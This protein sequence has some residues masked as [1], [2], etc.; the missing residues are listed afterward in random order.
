MATEVTQSEARRE[1]RLFVSSPADVAA[2]RE[3]VGRVIERLDSA[4]RFAVHLRTIRWEQDYYTADKT[5]Q[6]KIENPQ[7]CDLVVSILW[8]RLGSELPPD[9]ERMPD[10]RPYPSGTVYELLKALE[11]KGQRGVPDVLVYRKTLGVVTPVEDPSAAQ[12]VQDQLAAVHR[13]WT[14]RFVSEQG[15]FL[16]GYHSF[17]TTE[18]F[19]AQFESH[20]RKWLA[21]QGLLGRPVTWPIAEKGSPFRGLEP[22]DV[23]HERILFGRSA[24]IENAVALVQ[25]GLASGTTFLLITGESGAGKSS[26]ARA[27]VIP[28]LMRLSGPESADGWRL[29]RM[30]PGSGAD[31]LQLLAEALF[32]KEA[33]PELAS[34][35]Y[36]EPR[37]LRV[38]LSLGGVATAL[39]VTRTLE[40]V[41]TGWAKAQGLDRPTRMRLV[42]LVD[43]LEELFASNIEAGLREEFAAACAALVE[44][45]SV[46][47]IATLR[48]DAYP[49]LLGSDALLRLKSAGAT[50]DVRTPDKSQIRE[51]VT[52][53]A[54]AAGL[55][56]DQ[57]PETGKRLNDV[58]IEDAA[59]QDAL[60]LLQFA[61]ERLYTQMAARLSTSGRGLAHAEAANLVLRAADYR[62]FGGLEGALRETAEGAINRV[63]TEAQSRLPRLVRA[64]LRRSDAG[65]TLE[66]A[67][68]AHFAEDGAALRLI[69]ALV[70]ARI[71]VRGGSG[72]SGAGIRFAHEAVRRSWPRV[73]EI[74][75]SSETFYR[76][77]GDVLAAQARWSEA[78]RRH[79][80]AED[81]LVTPGVPLAEAERMASEYRD[82]LTSETLAFIARSGQRARRRQRWLQAAAAAFAV[83]FVASAAAGA[84]AWLKRGEASAAR[85]IAESERR[86]AEQQRKLAVEQEK[87]AKEQRN[88]ALLTQSRFLADLAN[89]R[90]HTGDAGTGILLALEAL[91]DV[92][93]GRERPFAPEAEV[94]LLSAVHQLKEVAILAHADKVATASF[95]PD[96]RRVVTTSE[97]KTAR[98][99]DVETGKPITAL[100][101]H[102]ALASAVF[103]PDGARVITASWDKTA[104]IWDAETGKQISILQGH[105]DGV[106]SAV[107]SPDGRRGLTASKD[108]TARVWETETGRQITILQ[109]HKGEVWTALFSPD[110]RR[111]LTASYDRTAR[112]WD[113]ETGKQVTALEGHTDR[114]NSSRFSPD[115]RRVLTAS[116][117]KTARLWD[118]QTGEPIFVLD[119]H[120]GAVTAAFSPDGRRVVTAPADTTA[121]VWD[122][123]TGKP[124][125]SLQ[126]HTDTI[127]RAAFSPDGRHIFTASNDRTARVWD[128]ATG[129]QISILKGHTGHLSSATFSPDGRHI[130]T[131][132]WD[133][134]ARLWNAESAEPI[135]I[136]GHESSPS[137][138]PDGQRILTIS[139]SPTARMWDVRV[140][141]SDTGKQVGI[142]QGHT[143]QLKSA[144]FS[145]DGLRI[146]TAS[147]DET[148]RIWDA[149]SGRQVAI[150]QGHAGQL[151]SAEFSPDARLVLTRPETGRVAQLWDA[152]TGKQIS[153]L[154]GHTSFVNSAAFSPDSRHVVTAS[155]DKTARVWNAATGREIAIL[156]G[157]TAAV[158]HAAFSPDGRRVVT[159]SQSQD[160]TARIWDVETGKQIAIL[161]GHESAVWSAAF[162]PDG[163]HVLTASND[164][165]ARIWDAETGKTTAVLGAHANSETSAVFSP[166]GRRVLTTAYLDHVVRLWD[167]DSGEQIA[168][169]EGDSP[170]PSAAFSPDGRRIAIASGGTVRIWPIF[171]STQDLI[172]RAKEIVPRCLTGEQR[173]A[174]FLAPEPPAWCIERQR[175]PYDTQDWKLWLKYM[176]AQAKPPFPGTPEWRSWLSAAARQSG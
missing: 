24:E 130:V 156:Q 107:F 91:P 174:A 76:V 79:V 152:A 56:F 101:G 176:R 98:V 170:L 61:L 20:L 116:W 89:Q 175:W 153:V 87:E 112:L 169:L 164:K 118:A 33:L 78:Q 88:Q 159:A 75:S 109:G 71:L 111:V 133:N 28:R 90:T 80:R 108:N 1:I 34:S 97:D 17:K 72:E 52:H 22:F 12:R 43:Q 128:A 7:S 160:K 47:L 59:G 172:D 39:P 158:T 10:G 110:G 139:F 64:L 15:H 81:Y 74:V 147:W 162:S 3:A 100:D 151:R 9:F 93:A 48:V 13:F 26:L 161:Q 95:S 29:A 134:T 45:G 57:D 86:Q 6:A 163:R 58:L 73:A 136:Q 42:L 171:P 137:F 165:T 68:L 132:S 146:V 27:G 18:E 143:G 99:W 94:A 54:D 41:A 157:H 121:R 2:E 40:R 4:F 65:Y 102:T 51:I 142:L 106:V 124:I 82:E 150:L 23:E 129:K 120:T 173:K 70:A 62:A 38:L 60:P 131:A 119:G 66:S 55:S 21:D 117:D 14:E 138:S 35:D 32:A 141:D 85:E 166:D 126:G 49:L 63:D 145:P 31:P 5:F 92:R 16:A 144:T 83:L 46:V 167:A 44:S 53:S 149:A 67:P 50:L 69:E 135:T 127:L 140:W 105:N 113:A 36:P 25:K 103:S 84:Y 123:E 19:E 168:N 96:G 77:R 11:A 37:L 104:R 8:S 125:L 114:V 148:A 154:K 115:G 155:T 122:T 30:L